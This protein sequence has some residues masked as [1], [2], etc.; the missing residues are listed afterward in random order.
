M[1]HPDP[2]VRRAA[3]CGDVHQPG[4]G[5]RTGGGGVA[6]RQAGAAGGP[7]SLARRGDGAAGSHR[8]RRANEPGLRAQ[9]RAQGAGPGPAG[10]S[11]GCS[12]R[13]R[14]G[15]GAGCSGGQP[16]R[17]RPWPAGHGVPATRARAGAGPAGER[18]RGMYPL[19]LLGAGRD[20]AEPQLRAR[21]DLGRR[22]RRS[23]SARTPTG[24]S[25]NCSRNA[26]RTGGSI[27]TTPRRSWAFPALWDTPSGTRSGFRWTASP[28]TS[29]R[30]S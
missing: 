21:G 11:V 26:A 10:R 20:L 12:G 23:R 15:S 3:G 8:A 14:T 7:G 22:T 28:A 5:G 25:S 2:S 30:E 1:P 24:R 17:D 16:G 18:V 13:W 29:P 27:T 19:V 9:L 6:G 4:V